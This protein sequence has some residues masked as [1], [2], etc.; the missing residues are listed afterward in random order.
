MPLAELIMP[1][2]P[3]HCGASRPFEAP[4]VANIVL[5]GPGARNE[6]RHIEVDLRGSGLSYAAGDALAIVPRN[7]PRLVDTVLAVLGI[8][9]H[10]EV[11]VGGGRMRFAQALATQF[12][13]AIATPRFLNLWAKLSGS[14]DLQ[15][16]AAPENTEAR[17]GFLRAYHIQD[18][19]RGWPVG[20]VAAEAVVA[21]LRPLQ[22]R[23]YSIASSPV[24]DPE[25]AAITLATLDYS[26]RGERRLGAVTGYMAPLARPGMT[27]P[28]FVQP[29]PRFRLRLQG[30][31]VMI[32]AGTG[33][34]P[35]RAF[36]AERRVRTSAGRAWLVFGARSRRD[37][38]IYADQWDAAIED[39]TLTRLDLAFSQDIAGK[40]YVQHRLLEHAA[41]LYAWIENG[42]SIYVC[43]D[44]AGMA[45]AV[46][47]ALLEIIAHEGRTSPEEAAAR[48][49]RLARDGRYC[50]SIY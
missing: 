43:G 12:D 21:G 35:F 27:L 22:P 24:V 13:I 38:F 10:A 16:L 49:R 26:L 6:K 47:A 3:P 40:V 4:V 31:I 2:A 36:V 41:E 34:A 23:L 19:V 5:T 8:D 32:G 28:V 45:P 30:D 17:R 11:R 33:V 14:A 1:D 15:A 9:G 50:R 18:I 46:H 25:R 48:L 42:A 44:A 37:D 39:G 20:G 7:D 29:E